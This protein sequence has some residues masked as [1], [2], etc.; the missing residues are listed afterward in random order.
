MTFIPIL[1]KIYKMKKGR[2]KPIRVR[3]KWAINP[4]TKIEVS[5]KIYFRPREKR[6]AVKDEKYHEA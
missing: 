5:D 1:C 2:K 6:K 4:K 3:K